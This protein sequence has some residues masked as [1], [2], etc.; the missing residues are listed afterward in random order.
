[1]EQVEN[2][3][4]KIN[5]GDV[6]MLQRL[7]ARGLWEE[8]K[9]LRL[10]LGC[11]HQYISGYI[12]IDYPPSE[13]NLAPVKADV[14]A[15]ARSLDFPAR[16]VDEIR[17]HHVFEHFNRVA[18]LG[19]PIKW[20]KWLK[21]GGKLH[22]ETPDLIGSAKT[23]PIESN[24]VDV[25]LCNQVI[26]HD[27]EPFKIIAEIRRILKKDGILILSAPQMGRL[28]GEP[29]DYYR[30]TKWGLTYLLQNNGLKIEFIEPHGGIFRAIGSHLN[31]FIIEYLG[32]NKRRRCILR[33]TIL[34]VNNFIFSFLD[35]FIT[36][37]KDTLG[38]NI[39]AKKRG[40]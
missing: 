22:I 12:N 16:S 10:H 5:D 2:N 9:V 26:E 38:Y 3:C 6:D 20:H 23:L 35:K 21:V 37:E 32:K 18:A 17:L 24:S 13:H 27:A 31:F 33:R 28:H 34:A 8:G 14:Y 40:H 25:V 19:M 4:V 7:K 39:I 29:N 15:D 30:F 1:M 36:W 11:G